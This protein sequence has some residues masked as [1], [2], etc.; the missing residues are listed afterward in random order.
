MRWGGSQP[1]TGDMQAGVSPAR[2]KG[3]RPLGG[4]CFVAVGDSGREACTA[5]PWDVGVEPR[6]IGISAG[7]VSFLAQR[8][9]CGAVQRGAVALPGSKA[10]WRAKDRIGSWEVS[11]LT[12]AARRCRPAS[13]R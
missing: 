2:D 11:G 6:K 3:R 4:D 8:Q 13:G 1:D 9:M 12:G 7:A 10:A 5:V